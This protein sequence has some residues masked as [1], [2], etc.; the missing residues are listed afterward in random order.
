MKPHRLMAA[1][2]LAIATAMT[3]VGT[4][5]AEEVVLATWGGT[6]GKAIAEQA[7]A[8]FEKATGIKVRVVSGVSLVNIQMIAAQRASPKIDLV[9]ATSQDAITA[10]DDGLLAPVDPAGVSALASLPAFGAPRDAQGKVMFAGIWVYPY[11]IVYRTD[12]VQ[13]PITCWKDLWRPDLA[14]KVAVS[15]PRYMNGLF[16]LMSNRMAGGN[17]QDVTP[18]LNLIKQMGRNLLAV[19]DDSASQQRLLAQGEVWAVPMVSSAAY[20][21]IDEGVTA[22]FVIPCEGAP[23]GMDVI[24]LVKNAPHPRAATQF[25]DFFLRADVIANVTRELKITP[26]NRDAKLT[27]EH[28]RYTVSDEAFSKLLRFDERAVIANRAAWQDLWDRQIAPMTLR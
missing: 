12:K 25:M 18:G 8:P 9:M 21:L 3:G 13:Q 22:K 17:E 28:A 10:Y 5:R 27:P 26:V 4:A 1:A 14:N 24:A 19:S 15:S 2:A 6:W 23:A 20:K 16:L 7:I 11:G